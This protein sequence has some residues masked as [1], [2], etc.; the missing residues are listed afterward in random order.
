ML[1]IFFILSKGLTIEKYPWKKGLT[2][3]T[4]DQNEVLPRKKSGSKSFS[5]HF[6]LAQNLYKPNILVRRKYEP[7]FSSSR[8]T[9]CKCGEE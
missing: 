5:H 4:R 1:R 8:Y 9:L 6:V 3:L 2:H 7:S